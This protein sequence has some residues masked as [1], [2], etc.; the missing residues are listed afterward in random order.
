MRQRWI[1]IVDN[2]DDDDLFHMHPPNRN[3]VTKPLLQYLPSSLPGYIIVTS[4]SEKVALKIVEYRDLVEIQPMDK[5][6]GLELLPK[7]LQSDD[8]EDSRKLVEEL[9]SMPLAIVQAAGYIR[10]RAPRYSVSRYL[11]EFRNSDREA[12]FP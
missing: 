5:S 1:L 7:K 3:A 9:E 11:A 8:N 6:E 4:R 10:S 12:R 2:I